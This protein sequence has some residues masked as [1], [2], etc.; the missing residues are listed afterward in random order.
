MQPGVGRSSI[1]LPPGDWALLVDFLA[2][3][4][5]RIGREVWIARLQQGKVFD[6]RGE[7]L[8]VDAPFVAGQV[9]RYF[10][11]V[12]HEPR[13][14]FEANILHRD[15]HL[16]VVDK[17][18]FLPTVPAGRFVRESLLMRLKLATG[19][20][21]L[22]P[23]HRLDRETA[24]LVLFSID[25]RSRAA[26]SALFAERRIDKVYEALAPLSPAHRFPLQRSS[27]IVA[28]EPFFRMREIDGEPNAHT[29]I[30]LIE[31]HH[32]TG[33]GRY[34][35]RPQTGKKHQLRL[36][37]AALG[38]PIENDRW[39]PDLL[40][41]SEDD[42]RKPLKLLARSLAF[43]DPVGGEQREFKSRFEL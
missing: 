8:S 22:A 28:G 31:T 4:F 30:E 12:E 37:M 18:H 3:H 41:E 7:P 27:R 5:A 14:P 36:H 39:Y 19:L 24:G 13:I 32:D 9:V 16:L 43:E 21:S 20:G 25:E 10:R 29:Q 17:P 2:E 15:E 6:A 1:Q 34:R 33:R 38:L 42:Y 23:L 26:Y 40:D 11:E 35:L